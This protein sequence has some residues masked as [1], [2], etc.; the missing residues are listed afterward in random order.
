[1]K[2]IFIE[3][4]QGVISK[5]LAT[6][7]TV[8]TSCLRTCTFIGA[9]GKKKFGAYHYPCIDDRD[10]TKAKYKHIIKSLKYLRGQV[11]PSEVVLTFA[12]GMGMGMGGTPGHDKEFLEKF[13]P[14]SKI[15]TKEAT[16]SFI[17]LKGKKLS[18]GNNKGILGTGLKGRDGAINLSS[19]KA[20]PVN[21]S[22]TLFGKNLETKPSKLSSDSDEEKKVKDEL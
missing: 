6:D 19:F 14:G 4:G 2:E 8:Y 16:A 3:M 10:K 18:G 1:M 17:Q 20:S 13:F 9:I 22:V 7:F 21:L 12:K 11:E 15:F 5:G